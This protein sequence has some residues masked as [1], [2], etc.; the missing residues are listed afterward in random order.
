MCA[1]KLR[2]PRSLNDPVNWRFSNFRATSA[3]VISESVADRVSGVTGTAPA[4]AAA[5]ARTSSTPPIS[6]FLPAVVTRDNDRYHG[7]LMT[8]LPAISTRDRLLEAAVDVFVEQGY[9]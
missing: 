1:R 9:E 5:A 8:A 4:I 7:I 2:A 3:P 6:P